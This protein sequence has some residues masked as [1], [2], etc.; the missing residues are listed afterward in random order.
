MGIMQIFTLLGA[1]GMFLYGMNLMSS[2]LQK[3]AGDKLRGFLAAITSN[4]FKGVATGLGVTTVIQSSSATTV[5]VV[6]F[7]NAGLLT[8]TQAISVIMGANIG[9]TVTAW[10]V[11]WLGFKADISILAIPLMALGFLFSNSK[12]NQR[13]NIGELIVGFSLLFLGL[14]F[15]KESVPDLGETPQVLDFVRAWSSHGFGSVLIFLAFGTVLTLVLQSSSATMAI[16]LIMLSMGWIPFNM[17]CA[18]V[19]G[20]N[21]GTTITANIAASVGNTQAKRAAMSHTIFN[22]FGVIWALILF[23]PFLALVGSIIELFGLPNPAAEGFVVSDPTS[24][25]GTAALYGLSMLHTLFNTINTLILVWF[26][27]YI[28]RAVTYIIKTPKN[29]ENEAFRLKYISAGPLATPELAT[30]QA[31][32]EIIH[33]AKISRNGLDYAKQAVGEKREDKFEEL[34]KKLVKYE[35]ISDRIEYEIAA[36][37]NEVAA[38]DISEVSSMRVKAMYKIIGELESLGDSG[39]AISRIL[40]RRNIHKKSFD[41][42]TIKNLMDMA[43]AVDGAYEAMITNLKAAHD[44]TLKDI[45]NAYNAEERINTLR[46]N[47]RDAEIEDIEDGGK[48]YQTSVYYMDIVNEFERMGDFIINISEDLDR[49]FRE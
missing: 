8:L 36:F 37:L 39:E 18:M 43:D 17:A 46:N 15:M 31:I 19:L 10:L 47:L 25:D 21:I 42:T 6:S 27:K 26:T 1:L 23:K 24:A 22:L 33:F 49:V 9:T 35:E 4:P 7:V 3:A 41:D 44:G 29:K 28:E 13:Q 34:R 32:K 2:G 40:S 5:M 48:N 11:S 12:R 16:T 38:G 45:S 30:E 20:E 14:S